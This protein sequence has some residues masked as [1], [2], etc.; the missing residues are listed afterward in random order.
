[1]QSYLIPIRSALITFPFIALLFTFP[2]AIYQYKKYGYINKFRIF[3]LYSFLLY[4]I[5]SYYF[6]I[7]P[8]PETRDIKSLQR[9][10]T[11]HYNLIPFSFIRDIVNETKVVLNEPSTYKYLLTERAFLQAAFNGI[12]LTPLGIYLR[13]YFK[14]GLKRTLTITFLVS[15][16]FEITQ[17]TGLFGIYNAPYRIFDVDDL[18]LNTLGGYIGYLLTPMFTFFLPNANEID[19][20]VNFEEMRVS[21][22]RRI[23]AFFIDMFVIALIPNI[24]ESIIFEEIVYF[25]YFILIVYFTNGKTVGKW[26]TSTRVKGQ[27]NN[28]KFKE[29]FIRYGVLYFGVFSFNKILFTVGELNQNTEIGYGIA[30]INI[31][32]LV[33]I[34][35]ILVHGVLCAIKKDRFFYEKISNTRIV[36]SK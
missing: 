3:I 5:T 24:R 4:L 1:M 7:L 21:Y 30:V 32:Q 23:L 22:F 12:L 16:F 25:V 17:I 8:L 11:Q 33:V 18:F 20:N 6:V 14:T 9:P 29:V 34:L 19:N 28:L 13:Y 27:E 35:L 2:F 31:I 36:V 26:L 10:G 15:L